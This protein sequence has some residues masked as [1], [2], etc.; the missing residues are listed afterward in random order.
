MGHII[1]RIHSGV[2]PPCAGDFDPGLQESR[3]S[4]LQTLLNTL[5][6]ALNLPATE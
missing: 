6:A 2:S 4:I 3:Q 1:D 5:S